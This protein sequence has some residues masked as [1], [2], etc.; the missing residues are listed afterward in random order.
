[1][2]GQTTTEPQSFG[3]GG[4][5]YAVVGFFAAIFAALGVAILVT[6]GDW[7][8]LVIAVGVFAALALL[9]QVL[10]LEVGPAGFRY[11]NLSGSRQV[12][13]ADL[14]RAYF[15]VVHAEQSP[16]PVA[17][18][19]VDRRAGKR[20]KVNLRTFP[21]RAAAVLFSALEAHGVAI[22]VPDEPSAR[23]VAD[24]VR[25]AQAKLPG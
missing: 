12:A 23:R 14:T 3:A 15:E 22:E 25:A 5:L 4:N 18:F 20:V 13:F 21:V 8:V 2:G 19:W 6:R 7:T 9:L 24:Q 17:A 16:R 1:M 10:R 11:R